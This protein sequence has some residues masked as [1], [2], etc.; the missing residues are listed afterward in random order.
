MLVLLGANVYVGV[1]KLGFL[2]QRPIVQL[3]VTGHRF[4]GIPC[5]DVP[6]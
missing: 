1:L 5:G 3:A 4:G 2:A 6:K